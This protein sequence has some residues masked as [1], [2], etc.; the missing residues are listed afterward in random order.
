[1]GLY[2]R[3]CKKKSEKKDQ[4]DRNKVPIPRA[5]LM[6]V[7]DI[8]STEDQDEKEGKIPVSAF[9]LHKEAMKSQ[10]PFVQLWSQ[11]VVD[12]IIGFG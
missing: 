6:L 5:D 12:P 3:L 2:K 8:V 11:G 4:D 1:M 9:S 10:N 7:E